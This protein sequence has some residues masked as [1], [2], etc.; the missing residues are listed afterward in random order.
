MRFR[1]ATTQVYPKSWTA[2]YIALDNVGMWN[3]RTEFWARQYLV[4]N[5]ICVFTHR[6]SHHEMNIQFQ[7][8]PS[9]AES[10]WQKN[11][12]S[13]D[14]QYCYPTVQDPNSGSHSFVTNICIWLLEDV[15]FL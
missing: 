9:F 7:E 1:A 15:S 3:I 12:I 13:I 11:Q 14:E 6:L 10:H 4:S 8:R 2:I 5:F